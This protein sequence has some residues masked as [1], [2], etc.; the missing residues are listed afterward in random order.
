MA[1]L[2]LIIDEKSIEDQ[3]WVDKYRPKYLKDIIMKQD[4]LNKIHQWMTHFKD[5]KP[6]YKNS[7][8]LW[9]PPGTGKTTI[10]NII[11]KQCDYDV[12]EFND[13]DKTCIEGIKKAKSLYQNYE[14]KFAN[15]GD[16]NNNTTPEK[17]FCDNNNIE[18]LFGIGGDD[19]SNSSSWIL[20]KWEKNN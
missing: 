5:K 1:N 6:G 17:E 13:S 19:K 9:G 15:G 3:L 2:K 8:L 12:I 18:T 7:L 20:K 16:R 11:L 14:I 10:A 4:N